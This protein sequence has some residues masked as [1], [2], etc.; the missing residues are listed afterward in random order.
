MASP[1]AQGDRRFPYRVQRVVDGDTLKLSNGESV[2]LVGVDTEEVHYTNKLY[3]DAERTH[4]DIETIR[5][6]GKQASSFTK[7]LVQGKR[8][9]LEFEPSNRVRGHRD[10]YERLL[11]Y[12]YFDPPPC[13]E[14]P[15]WVAA[16]ICELDFYEE[17]HLNALIIEAGY[18]YAYTRFPF[19]KM[20]TFRKLEKEAQENERGLWRPEAGL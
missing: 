17:G 15:D 2:R 20:E 14:L 1:I 19:S 16:D 5:L 6:L 10:P 18:G 11:A 7:A 13:D 12:V 4:R 8:V 3:R 9:A